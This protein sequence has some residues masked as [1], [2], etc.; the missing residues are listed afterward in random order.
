MYRLQELVS[1]K[2]LIKIAI[3]ATAVGFSFL[4]ALALRFEFVIPQE[5]RAHFLPAI[6]AIAL[7][8]LLGNY[9]MRIYSGHWKYAS[10][11]ELIYLVSAATLS[12]VLLVAA[13][14]SIPGVRKYVPVSVAAIGGV[15]SLFTMAFVRLQFRFLSERKLRRGER[16]SKKVLLIGAGEAGE[17]VARDMLRLREHD[18]SP[19]GFVDDDPRKRNLVIQGVPVLGGREEIPKI[20]A[21]HDVDEIF[22]TMPSVAGEKIKEMLPYCE[23]T[24]AQI[25]ILPGIFSMMSGDIGVA[26]VRELRLEDLLGR[27]PVSTDVASISAYVKDRVVMVTGAGGSIGSELARQLCCVGP[28][29][30]L[31]LDNDSTRLYELELEMARHTAACPGEVVVADIRDADRLEAVFRCHQPQVVFHSAALKHVPLMEFHPGEAVK[32][33]VMGTRNLA[34]L[35]GKYN[36]ERFILISTDKAV[37]PASVMGATKRVAELL[38]KGSNGSDGTLFTSVRFGNVLGSR[39]S[40]V[41][42]FQKQIEEGGPLLV[43]HP[44]VTRYFMTIEEAA[45]LVIQA[46]AYTEGGDVFILDMGEPV[47][48][49][50]IANQMVRLL[51]RGKDIEIRVTGLR[52]GEKLE[53]RLLFQSEEMLPTPHPK[54]NKAVHDFDL[55]RDFEAQVDAL[56]EAA[57]GDDGDD[58]RGLLSGLLP[59]YQPGAVKAAE[60]P[61]AKEPVLRLVE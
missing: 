49:I 6:P 43:T 1:D 44:E 35:A 59:S 53:E 51:G 52:P 37:H 50:D 3:D 39:G 47:R 60:K 7:L 27:E 17:M 33:N 12:T 2:K 48:I 34:R 4:L 11:D 56:I 55:P 38:I 40:V 45:E 36:A 46:G 8:Y 58:V 31:L 9:I 20:A 16:G 23:V 30:L 19:V 14:L 29:K 25:K 42:L 13:V 21:E 26:A 57:V 5:Y 61:D 54:I 22:I 10:F 41:P 28:S 24:G 32:S 15:L 18:Y